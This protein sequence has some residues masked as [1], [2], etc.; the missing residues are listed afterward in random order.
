MSMAR[1][2]E[3][4]R[5]LGKMAMSD[6]TFTAEHA[7]R[8]PLTLNDK[9]EKDP[10]LEP[11]RGALLWMNEQK[12]HAFE[13]IEAA[14][15]GYDIE[16]HLAEEQRKAEAMARDEE[17]GDESDGGKD[18][19][20]EELPES[21]RDE[22][23]NVQ[24]DRSAAMFRVIG[25]MVRAGYSD[26][27]IL[28]A[29]GRGD[30]FR[31][32]YG[33]RL[34]GE[35]RRCMEK[36]RGGRYVYGPDVAPPIE[37]RNVPV[38]TS[39]EACAPLP[40]ALSAM[41][42]RYAQ[43]CGIQTSQ[44]VLDAA[45]FHEHM[46]QSQPGGVLESPCG[47]GKSTWAICH[48]ALNASESNRYLYVLETVDA[49]YRAA[50]TLEKL[51]NTP[52]GRLHGFNPE[53][54]ME[55]CGA[56]H[57]WRDCLHKDP[58]SAC[59]T[60][61]RKTVCPFYNRAS[62]QK[63]PIVCMTHEGLVRALEEDSELLH[64]A[65]ILVD[66]DLNAF[67]SLKVSLDDLIHL[68]KCMPNLKLAVFLPHSRLSCNGDLK[69]HRVPEGSDT[70]AGRNCVFRNEEETAKLRPAYNELCK[71]LAVHLLENPF[72][73]GVKSD[74]VRAK[75]TLATLLNFFR[76]SKQEDAFYAFRETRDEDGTHYA[77]KRSRYSL[78]VDRG[79][80]KLWILN[81]SA[82]LSPFPCPDNF[83]V[84][85]C[86]ELAGNSHLV[87]LHVA[88]GQPMKKHLEENVWLSD[89]AM[90]LGPRLPR[91]GHKKVLVATNKESKLL[92][93]IK[94]KIE[95]AIAGA[96]IAHMARGRIKGS[97]VAG[98]CTLAFISGMAVF[99]TID[100]CALHAAL[101]LRRTFPDYPN[102]FSKNG[103]PN[104][105]GGRFIVPAMR[106]YYALR[107]LDEIYQTI[108]R[109]AVRNDKPVEAIITVP[110][111]EWLVALWRTVM[112]RFSL[113]N[114]YKAEK[115]AG[116]IESNGKPVEYVDIAE[117]GEGKVDADGKPVVPADIAKEGEG[118]NEAKKKTVGYAYDFTR[119]ASIDGLRII[120]SPPG[121]EFKKE[122]IADGFDYKGDEAWKGNKKRIMKLL[123]PFF[124][125][126]STNRVLRRK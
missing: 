92:D 78:A 103:Q 48:V 95:N 1:Y 20:Y 50:A 34:D 106:Q 18:A 91:G 56:E 110:E 62:E 33:K 35:A 32:K 13:D 46:F 118:K 31:Q 69:L 6:S 105:P 45:R 93:D 122:Q 37:I 99:T 75:N 4:S 51:T 67:S 30:E 15:R 114:A 72:P 68:Q 102:V 101:M 84:H 87:K 59:R 124:E 90:W 83:S 76:P 66:E 64:G 70:F 74:P 120:C 54:C 100:D 119:D 52:V 97:N 43:A 10:K 27:T 115:G 58:E 11:V 22:I 117:E 77:L 71:A 23:E 3:V 17:P 123:G 9:R 2:E 73:G 88:T 19:P 79:Y 25:K 36:V 61:G 98:E 42:E 111:P 41:L 109:T 125:E 63:K 104:M 96:E 55:L 49:L 39:L 60:C 24:G 121:Q 57:S 113:G 85:E 28:V 80:R 81:A 16:D 108:W 14:V 21:I 38:E 116:L 82:Q 112:P 86:P 89:V 107:S 8:V 7:F 26:K 53:K 94:S 126:G 65:N 12:R 5:K 40:P 29:I 44:R 47:S